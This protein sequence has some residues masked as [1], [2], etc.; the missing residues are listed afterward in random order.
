M[1]SFS[2]SWRYAVLRRRLELLLL[3]AL[4]ALGLFF[5]PRHWRADAAAAYHATI[6]DQAEHTKR[7]TPATGQRTADRRAP[8]RS[9]NPYVRPDICQP[10]RRPALRSLATQ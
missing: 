4:L 9:I 10:D 7:A 3:A 2:L 6:T 8:R 1:R 5:L